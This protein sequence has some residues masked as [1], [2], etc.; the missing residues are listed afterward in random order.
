MNFSQPLESGGG[1]KR[2]ASVTGGFGNLDRD[3]FNVL[4]SLTLDK[5]DILRGN[6]RSWATGFQPGRYLAPDSSSHP[7]ANIINV[8]NTALG[9]AGSTIGT[10]PTKYT[11]INALSLKGACDS[12]PTGVQ[13][14][15]QLWNASAAAN[16]YIC[17]TD[18]G[19]QYMLAAPRT[20]TTW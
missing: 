4:A 10:D 20:P 17:A 1:T 13:Y 9:A 11:R 12:I 16:R 8:A 2:R 7:F 6:E 15:P 3:R 18:Y 5:D 19:A 14:Q